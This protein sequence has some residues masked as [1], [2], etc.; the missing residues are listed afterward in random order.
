LE[1]L[2]TDEESLG[3]ALRHAIQRG[4][5]RFWVAILFAACTVTAI[6]VLIIAVS[7]QGDTIRSQG[8]TIGVL[9]QRDRSLTAIER[10]LDAV[11]AFD[12]ALGYVVIDALCVTSPPSHD[13]SHRCHEKPQGD[14]APGSQN[15]L[16]R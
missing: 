4:R 13:W 1:R 3:I 10:Q 7:D 9:S 14:I 5:A 12:S 2:T 16:T 11:Q 8:A 6:I 15:C